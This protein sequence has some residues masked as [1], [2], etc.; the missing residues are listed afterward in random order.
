MANSWEIEKILLE[1]VVRKAGL[2]QITSGF[3]D[4]A[5]LQIQYMWHMLK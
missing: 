2:T 4:T 1:S 5:I 3:K